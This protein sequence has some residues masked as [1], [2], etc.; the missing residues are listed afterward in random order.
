M[1]VSLIKKDKIVDL[2]LPN[3]IKGNYWIT[4]TDEHGNERNLICI[5][6]ND[7]KW[8]LVS[9]NEVYCVSN[10]TLIPFVILEVNKF[11]VLKSNISDNSM[12]LYCSNVLE[13]TYVTYDISS[14]KDKEIV[15]GNGKNSDILYDFSNI[16]EKHATIKFDG[17][18]FMFT[19]YGITYINNNIVNETVSLINGDVIFI[20]GLKII[21]EVR[22]NAYFLKVNNINGLVG[23]SML[24]VN[25]NN[26]DEKEV[27][28]PD[29]ELD[30]TLYTDD[31]KFH[32][33]PRFIREIEKLELNIDAPPSKQTQEE[34]PWLLIVGPMLTMSMMSVVTAFTAINNITAN[35]MSIANALPSLV[36]SGVMLCGSLVWPFV[37]RKY[38]EGKRKKNEKMRQLK[39][40]KYIDEKRNLIQEEKSKQKNILTDS[41]PN[42]L[43]CQNIILSKMTR[44][45]ERRNGDNDFLTINLGTG[46]IDMEIDIKYPEEHFTMVEDNLTVTARELGKEPKQ[47]QDAS[48][49]LSLVHDNILGIVGKN[50]KISSYMSSLL[51]QIMAFHSYDDLKIVMLT[52]KEKAHNWNYL[53]IL[54]HSFSNDRGIRFFGVNN[55]EYKEIFYYLEKE[56]SNRFSEEN[57]D[58]IHK[59]HY[60]LITDNFKS[61]RNFD[62]IKRILNL[63]EDKGF[64]LVILTEKITNIPDQCK[65]FVNIYQEKAELYKNVI[66]N[67]AQLFNIDFS[68]K[69]KYYDC[70]KTLS[71]IYIDTS[72]DVEGQLPNKLS[73][74]QM[75]DVGKIEQLNSEH[76]WKKNNPILSLASPV[77]QGKSGEK[78]VIDLHEKYHGPHGLIA[79]MTGSGKSEFII[80]YI[81]SMAINYHP[82]EV[83][84]IL[85]DYKGG[86]LA[87][88]FENSNIGLKL[89]HLVGTIT[90]LDANE[91]NRSLASIESELKR[92]QVLFNL[93]REKSGEST[94]D[95]YKYQKMYRDGLVSEPISHLFIISDE[96]AELKNQQP[97]FMQQLISTARI[98]RSLGVHLILATQKPS[99]VVDPQIWSNTRFRVCLRVQEKSDSTEVIKKPDAAL[100]K[101]T[102]R[103]Y[104][105]VGFDE[106]FVLGQAAWCGANYIPSEKIRKELDT[107]I[108]FIDNLGYVT[109]SLET[110]KQVEVGSSCGE[111]LINIV[112]Y[113]ALVAKEENVNCKSLWLEKIPNNIYV[114]NLIKKYNYQKE[115]F[116]INPVVGE[117][118]DPSR[119]LQ[120]LLTVPIS[121]EGNALVYGVTGSGKESFLMTMLYSSMISYTPK[122]V[123]YYIVDFGSEAINS[124]K[125]APIVGDVLYSTDDEKLANLYKLLHEEVEKRKKLFSDFN[126]DYTTYCKKSGDSLPRIITIINN[127]EAYQETFSEFDDTLNVLSRDGSRY[128]INFV[129]SVSTPNGVRFK[130]RQ[131][132]NQEFVLQQNNDDD[133]VTILGNIGK[134]Y[135]SNLFGRGIVKFDEV[136]EFQTALICEKDKIQDYVKE[137]SNKQKEVMTEKA[138]AVPILPDIV[139]YNDIKEKLG[140]DSDVIVGIAKSSLDIVKFDFKKNL[141]NLVTANDIVN[142]YPFIKP[143]INQLMYLNYSDITFINNEEFKLEDKYFNYIEY[144]DSNF[145]EYFDKLYNYI[146]ERNNEYKTNNYSRSI[147]KNIKRKTIIILG[148]DNL[149]N[150]LGLEKFK[151]LSEIFEKSKDL[152]II[153]FVF[154]DSVDK[155]KK[156]EL[157]LWYKSCVNNTEGIWIGNG[158]NDQFSLKISQRTNELKEILADDFCFVVKRGKPILVKFV[159][160]LEL[161]LK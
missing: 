66:N 158:I 107:S 7:G 130:L 40:K 136:Y 60:L 95:I 50:E 55:D 129:L 10:D 133:Y 12:I 146:N 123:N 33:K 30:I 103:F 3:V 43:E 132:F 67:K 36:L 9:N 37:N 142:I 35:N 29:E 153:N 80:T 135:P 5:E 59:P 72:F 78:I 25:I 27:I 111:E 154:I 112:K 75:Y 119:Q 24:S 124:F 48:I 41:Y 104:F 131:N 117:Y 15:I 157:E 13:K 161:K 39:Y 65:S 46:N 94:I 53:K 62:T 116:V 26:G 114:N 20:M 160:N 79:G 137:L 61:I 102:G 143:F 22:N 58:E 109:K 69:Y 159:T 155:V 89:P 83:Q 6:A 141:I 23:C 8:K 19:P 87:G 2:I 21:F 99:G 52:N 150:K 120:H 85:I 76:R 71:N 110:K 31:D 51:L 70:A 152:D 126:G 38:E 56:L 88:A 54:P 17:N 49:I 86:G 113:L 32:K 11:Y 139:S 118:D 4:D 151:K 34:K 147:F 73:F 28:E 1:R 148:I 90:N 149:K 77:G 81:L 92:R 91:I 74:L 156:Y 108:D 18:N 44:L 45:W 82:Y 125:N 68:N 122:E 115:N 47:I 134:K 42:T 128:G 100:L 63:D 96:F 97:E 98:G 144:I 106:I 127:F 145:D 14:Y 140:K 64:S 138:R 101:Q 84:F 16:L 121:S 105:Q 57:K 93:A